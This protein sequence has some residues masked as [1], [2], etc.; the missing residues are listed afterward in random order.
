MDVTYTTKS[1]KDED[2]KDL[3]CSTSSTTEV[4]VN[5][6]LSYHSTKKLYECSVCDYRCKQVGT[7]K[8]HIFLHTGVKP[9]FCTEC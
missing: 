4:D 5:Q 6:R 9:Y 8:R 7:L 2:E 3:R 1:D